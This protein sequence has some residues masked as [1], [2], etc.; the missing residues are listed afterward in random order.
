MYTVKS[1]DSDR[2]RRIEAQALMAID[3]VHRGQ[4]LEDA[5]IE[6][7]RELI[8]PPKAARRIAGH[9]NAA[10]GEAALWIVGIDEKTGALV[11]VPDHTDWWASVQQSFDGLAPDLTDLRIPIDGHTLL[12]LHFWPDRGPFVFRNPDKDI[13][14]VPWRD[15]TRIRSAKREELLRLLLPTQ[16]RP[17]V[18]ILRATAKLIAGGGR[19]NNCKAEIDLYVTPRG[20]RRIVYPYH[21][22]RLQIANADGCAAVPST[23]PRV[24]VVPYATSVW[25]ENEIVRHWIRASDSEV[26]IEEPGR[27]V[28]HWAANLEY[29]MVAAWPSLKLELSMAQADAAEPTHLLLTLNRPRVSARDP[30]GWEWSPSA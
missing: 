25:N 7:K 5:R 15:A 9:L 21:R 29:E 27:L 19:E 8:P 14:E 17:D 13:L 28:I 22:C 20:D 1:D 23:S 10:L 24:W 4:R 6:L 30:I 12:A 3:H 18:E 2:L 16:R 11:D 26:L